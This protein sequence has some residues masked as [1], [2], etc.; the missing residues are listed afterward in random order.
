MFILCI[1]A[2]MSDQIFMSCWFSCTVRLV[3]A[4]CLSHCLETE[5]VYSAHTHTHTLQVQVFLNYYHYFYY[6]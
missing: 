3:L 4:A 5:N 1:R 2:V 6:Y